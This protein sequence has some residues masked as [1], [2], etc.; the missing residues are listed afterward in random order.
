MD[1]PVTKWALRMV[2]SASAQSL[3]V[4]R[5]ATAIAGL[6]FLDVAWSSSLGTIPESMWNPPLGTAW[7]AEI[8]PVDRSLVVLAAT[9]FTFGLL[10]TLAGAF[11]RWSASAAAMA[12]LYLG[13]V[14]QLS[15]KTDHYHHTL[16][17]LLIMAVAPAADIW[18]VDSWRK[19]RLGIQGRRRR[20]SDYAL[21]LATIMIIIGLIYFFAGFAKLRVGGLSWVFSD[22]L[23][24][25]M[26]VLWW[27]R[28]MEGVPLVASTPISQ[29]FAL[30]TV[31]FEIAF[32]PVALVP[33][34][35]KYAVAAGITFHLGTWIVLGIS[36]IALQTMYVV[37]FNW[38]EVPQLDVQARSDRRSPRAR[39]GL[40]WVIATTLLV[41]V[42]GFGFAHVERSWP[43]AAYPTFT[44]RS[45]PSSAELVEVVFLS[46]TGSTMF[47]AESAL[48]ER[49]TRPHTFA[50]MMH[51]LADLQDGDEEAFTDFVALFQQAQ[52]PGFGTLVAVDGV[53]LRLDAEQP[54]EIS[55]SRLFSAAD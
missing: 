15:G 44:A 42:I 46:Q 51:A 38:S 29:I 52:G 36:F 5:M 55:R 20:R 50:M 18:S 54:E 21:P 7:L 25:I 11:N 12:M 8:V 32:L 31:V 24:N 28:G 10:G 41:G 34:W 48:A 35:R 45:G 1:R 17:F 27:Q 47:L 37:F 33:K 3:A 19:R 40:V 43:M 13:W 53:K 16:W 26:H 6:F 22:N 39:A 2:P 23:S 9:I 49:Y 30:V 4:T 14:H